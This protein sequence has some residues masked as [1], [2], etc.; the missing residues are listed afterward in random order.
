MTYVIFVQVIHFF[1][2][3]MTLLDSLVIIFHGLFSIMGIHIPRQS[4]YVLQ[5]DF[6]LIS[7]AV[8]I[9]LGT[10]SPEPDGV[11]LPTWSPSPWSEEKI[12]IRSA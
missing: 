5:I 11:D 1:V 10:P 7:R 3:M 6:N 2:N 12:S 8:V 9:M 4:K